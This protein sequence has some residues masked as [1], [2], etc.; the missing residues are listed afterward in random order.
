MSNLKQ[1]IIITTCCVLIAFVFGIIFF[2]L[3]LPKKIVIPHVS[4]ASQ[5]ESDVVGSHSLAPYISNQWYSSLENSFPGYPLY[6]LPLA[7]RVTPQGLGFSYPKVTRK[8]ATIA[9]PYTEDFTVGF[10]DPF[11]Q[12][13]LQSVTDWTIGAK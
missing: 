5:S 11:D 13:H 4:F 8:A 3:F 7:V 6:A 1:T 12:V 2:S 9:A 10:S